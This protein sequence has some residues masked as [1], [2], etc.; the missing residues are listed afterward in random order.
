MASDD[1]PE[2]HPSGQEPGDDSSSS[3]WGP[4]DYI[5][6]LSGPL[7]ILLLVAVLILA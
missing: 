3:E 5:E 7:I 4:V 6:V 1:L 2:N